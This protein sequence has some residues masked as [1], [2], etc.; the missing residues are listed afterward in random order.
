[1]TNDLET[2]FYKR[3]EY[4]GE[5]RELVIHQL[6][7]YR[8]ILSWIMRETVEIT[9]CSARSFGRSAPA[10]LIE[11]K[12]AGIR[13]IRP[14]SIQEKFAKTADLRMAVQETL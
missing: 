9:G 13:P 3:V 10:V 5:D 8:L 12:K 2:A 11:W 1:M 7:T 14:R 4:F 6:E